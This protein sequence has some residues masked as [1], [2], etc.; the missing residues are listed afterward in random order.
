M[1]EEVMKEKEEKKQKTEKV[2]QSK[3]NKQKEGSGKEEKFKKVEEKPKKLEK[4]IEKMSH[5]KSKKK[6]IA[7]A[8]IVGIIILSAI[9]LSTI[10]A[11]VNVGN[12]KMIS[13]ISISGI[14]VSGL[15]KEEAKGKIEAVYNEKQEK[16]IPLKYEEYETSL[17]K[18]IMEVNYKIDEAIE[19]AYKMG[20][21][22][23]IFL[24]N[25]DILFT[26]IGKKNIPVK[27]EMNEDVTKQTIKDINI[28]LPGVV[29]ES[30]YSVEEDELIITKGQAGIVVDEEKLLKEIKENLDDVNIKDTII[31]IPVQNKA[32]EE[33]NIDKIHEEVYKEAKDA[34]YT[35]DPYTVYPEVEGVDFDVETAKELL[36]EEKE[37]YVIKLIITKPKVT[38]SQIGDE[39]FPNKLST[40]TT[41]YD[42]S[43]TNRTTNLI[44]ACNKING[45]VVL[46][47][48]TFSYNKALGPR[49]V[50]AGYRNG[51][52]YSGGEVV[53]GIGGGICQI[54]STLYN[55]ILEAN[56]ETVER[57]NHQ[58][59]TSYLPA[60]R[61]ATVVYGVTDFKFKNTRQYPVRIVASARNGIATVSIYGI[62]EENEYTFT[63][64]TNPIASIPFTTQYIED[65]SLP[66]GTEK[67]KQKGANG[68]RT[69]TYITKMLNGKVISTKLLSK[70]TYSAMNRIVIK[71]TKAGTTTNITP[72]TP[73]PV[74][75]EP[76][77]PEETQAPVEP[78]TPQPTEPTEP[79]TQ[80]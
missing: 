65:S 74:T 64:K 28:N 61:D 36:K 43:D 49:T 47:G 72:T 18:E 46:P 57:R 50:E 44:I 41:R 7:V 13:G 14:E 9:L 60:G 6:I 69:E 33:I 40:C 23:N 45:K 54:S 77:V 10:F 70:D 8:V 29:I 78:T 75:P 3:E 15:S 73:E 67:I 66:E 53:D 22:E 4:E 24:S 51:K 1:K 2:T 62:K 80:E 26:L 16:E 39:A 42:V 25:Y 27:M 20:R 32:P 58:F 11:L 30:S 21:K 79:Q 19:T 17:N 71:G 55:A 59:V 37:E 68:L 63:F 35:K 76:T 48:E 12:E 31:E 52:I 38:L 56:L 34:Y 5:K